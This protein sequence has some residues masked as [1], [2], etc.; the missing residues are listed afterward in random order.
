MPRQQKG[1]GSRVEPHAGAMGMQAKQGKAKECA[2]GGQEE[3]GR[4][5]D[6]GIRRPWP[7][8]AR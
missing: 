1:P 5:I 8:A 6:G 7:R 4:N 2:G 3:G